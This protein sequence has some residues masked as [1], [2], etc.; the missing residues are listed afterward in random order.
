M[1]RCELVP[2][3]GR[4]RE[5]EKTVKTVLQDSGVWRDRAEATVLMRIATL[6]L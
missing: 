5:P 3:S 4:R 2:E 1:G 6:A